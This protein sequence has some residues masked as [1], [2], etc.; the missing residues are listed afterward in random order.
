MPRQRRN[1]TPAFRS[2][3]YVSV[4]AGLRTEEINALLRRFGGDERD[5]LSED[6]YV[7]TVQDC[8]KKIRNDPDTLWAFI[9]GPSRAAV[10]DTTLGS[11]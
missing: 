2:I 9:N 5:M 7:A 3:I 1:A 10:P 8:Y 6:S 4:F 11:E